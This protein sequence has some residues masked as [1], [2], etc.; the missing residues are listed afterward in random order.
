[1]ENGLG[2]ICPECCM[3]WS[4]NANASDC[5]RHRIV[6]MVEVRSS[7]D[8]KVLSKEE[9]SAM[10]VVDEL[11]ASGVPPLQLLNSEVNMEEEFV[12]ATTD[13]YPTLDRMPQVEPVM[14]IVVDDSFADVKNR[15]NK[16]EKAQLEPL[17]M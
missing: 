16:N 8:V 14:P 2:V 10:N 9:Q 7:K 13:P 4:D 3:E 17:R 12:L 15:R 1:M 11:I 6:H 5:S